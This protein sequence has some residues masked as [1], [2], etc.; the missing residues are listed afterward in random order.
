MEDASN[1][2]QSEVNPGDSQARLQLQQLVMKELSR[3]SE[4][5]DGN[6]HQAWCR[7]TCTAAHVLD[8]A[9][10]SVWLYND[11]RTHIN[12]VCLYQ[13][14]QR[15]HSFATEQQSTE[16]S[17]YFQYLETED[18]IAADDARQDPRT[19]S[20]LRQKLAAHDITSMMDVPIRS[21]GQVVGIICLK[22]GGSLRHWHLEEQIFARY[23]ANLASLAIQS[24]ERR[25][26]EEEL[27]QSEKRYRS[28]VEDQ[29][30]LICRYLPD[31]TLTFVNE[32]YCRHFGQSRSQLLGKNFLSLI[33]EDERPRFEQHLA[34]ISRQNPVQTNESQIFLP[35]GE[36]IWMQ[37]TNRAIF[38]TQGQI[39]EYQAVGRDITASKQTEQMRDEFL[40]ITSHEL[41]TPLTSLRGSL[42]LLKTGQLGTLNASGQK[43]LDFA[44][45]DTERLVRLVNDLLT[46]QR[47]KLGKQALKLEICPIASLIEQALSVVQP[48]ADDADISISVEGINASVQ[49]DCDRIIQVLT[50]LLDNAIKF[51]P[52]E[53][54][55]VVSVHSQSNQICCQVQDWGKGIRAEQLETIFEPFSQADALDSRTYEGA[56]LGLAICRSIIEQHEGRIWAESKLGEGSKFF[57]VLDRFAD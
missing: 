47:L 52:P 41:R 14:S 10:V 6:L 32:A 56:G 7:I 29:T 15:Q 40:A 27:S 48:L 38:D 8:I 50:N 25:R 17:A 4:F 2:Q 51:S 30:E 22:H 46:I 39:I 55:V 24:A 37:W 12:R 54:R 36:K 35:D 5:Y 49:V 13:L 9:R 28:V 20:A 33:A 18:I 31:T 23:L 26:A 45:L 16:D 19:C 21:G 43:M 53:G 11:S 3:C 42:G 34:A 57:F 1:W 44:L